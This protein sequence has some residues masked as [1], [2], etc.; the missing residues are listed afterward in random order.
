MARLERPGTQGASGHNEPVRSHWASS[1]W[2]AI[3]AFWLAGAGKVPEA[4]R[5]VQA[6]VRCELEQEKS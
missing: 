5:G 2:R 1:G 4:G 6:P 3:A